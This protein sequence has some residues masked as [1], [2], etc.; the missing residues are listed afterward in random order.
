MRIYGAIVLACW[1]GSR[2]FPAAGQAAQV[3]KS[4]PTG[5]WGA[6]YA[7]THFDRLVYTQPDAALRFDWTTQQ[8]SRNLPAVFS[9]RWTGWL[10]APASGRYTFAL[11]PELHAWVGGRAL[12]PDQH[13]TLHLTKGTYYSLRVEY[14]PTSTGRQAVL[15]WALP[16]APRAMRPLGSPYLLRELPAPT[17]PVPPRAGHFIGGTIGI[18]TPS[19]Y[20]NPAPH[21][22]VAVTLSKGETVA[23][24]PPAGQGLQATYYAGPLTGPPVL[25]RVEPVVDAT[26]RGFSPTPGVPGQGFSVR[27]TGYLRAPETGVY[28]LHT[29]W[30]DATDVSFAGES[31]L[32]MAKYE[33]GFF[34]PPGPPIPLDNLQYYE[35]G[36]FYR[37][38]L[39]YKDIQGVSRAILSW[40][41][42][43]EIGYPTHIEQAFAAAGGHRLTV[44]PQQFLYPELPRPVP[45][46]ASVA[47]AVRKPASRPVAAAPAR[48]VSPLRRTRPGSTQPVAA[49]PPPTAVALPDLAALRPG[50]AVTLPNLYF[51]QSTA[52]LLPTSRPVLTAL[53]RELRQHPAVRLELAGHT[54]NVGDAAQNLLLSQRRAQVVRR[55]LVQQGIDSVRLSARGYGGT[56]PVADN[57][58]LQQ[59]PRNRRVEAVV[60]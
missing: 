51:T 41:R 34:G 27:W 50:T 33:P 11:S 15:S 46:A 8:P 60:Q 19:S 53:V 23:S 54:D 37:I 56:R 52:D 49:P 16:T 1:L 57:R 55:Y 28:V 6:Y 48:P 22:D 30:D 13:L 39:A 29:Q 18:V 59:R 26:W 24:P 7:G 4:P 2:T 35:A 20:T 58:D 3:V 21:A 42:P 40:V 36:K 17:Q 12:T 38:E 14:E 25:R 47:G 32:A 45:A 10:L 31:I 43:S 9:V 5:L 44:I